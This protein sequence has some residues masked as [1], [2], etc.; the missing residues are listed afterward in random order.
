[1]R[2]IFLL[3]QLLCLSHIYAQ[4]PSDPQSAA[5]KNDVQRYS[6]TMLLRADYLFN[7][8]SYAYWEGNYNFNKNYTYLTY[9]YR[10]YNQIGYE[11]AATSHWYLGASLK[12]QWAY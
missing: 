6:P 11:H 2:F 10:M 7:K 12:Y 1:M 4:L 5:V 3:C 8:G 9:D